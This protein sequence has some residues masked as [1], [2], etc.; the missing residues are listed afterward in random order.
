M[1]PH[2]SASAT[3]QATFLHL[4]AGK[5][6][7]ACSIHHHDTLRDLLK[8]PAYLPYTVQLSIDHSHLV[9]TEQR[10]GILYLLA[11]SAY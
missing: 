7:V 10:P 8:A 1:L 4:R 9:V 11:C 6:W 5:T 2:N 3:L